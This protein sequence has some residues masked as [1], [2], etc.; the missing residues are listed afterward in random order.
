MRAVWAALAVTALAVSGWT[1]SAPPASA[2]FRADFSN[3]ATSPSRWT[4]A[5]HPDGRGHF[6]SVMGPDPAS[7]EEM[8]VP[9]VDRDIQV[10]TGFAERVF[11]IA[12]RHKYFNA[13]CDSG[14]KVAFQGWKTFSYSGPDG[15]GS[16]RFNYSK[17]KQIQD[18]EYSLEAVVQ[19][20]LEG[21]RLKMYLEHDRLGLDQEMGFLLDAA[22]DGRAQQICTIRSIL[23][24]LADDP[25]VM[26][27]VRKGARDLL[28]R[29]D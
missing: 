12:Q 23:K 6:R 17:D 28:A 22:K 19:T 18:L 10:S 16:C 27:R 11:Q 4:L 13:P 15:N 25:D 3:P 24:R 29:A 20:I 9:D 5:L 26:E 21:E 7:A 2:V 8:V 14:L 1:Q